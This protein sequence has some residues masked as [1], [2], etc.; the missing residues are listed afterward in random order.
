MTDPTWT[1]SKQRSLSF[2]L[3]NQSI[4]SLWHSLDSHHTTHLHHLIHSPSFSFHVI[5]SSFRSQRAST[6]IHVKLTFSRNHVTTAFS[7]ETAHRHSLSPFVTKSM[8]TSSPSSFET[9]FFAFL[10]TIQF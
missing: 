2:L 5:L 1:P 3:I 4:S 10:L 8:C 9:S 6:I 7:A